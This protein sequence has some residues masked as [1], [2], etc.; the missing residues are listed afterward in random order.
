MDTEKKIL[1]SVSFMLL[2]AIIKLLRTLRLSRQKTNFFLAI[3]R[4]FSLFSVCLGGIVLGKNKVL[5]LENEPK[6]H[7]K[8]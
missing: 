3:S 1:F 5:Y 4:Q 6:Y 7:L 8:Q 2:F